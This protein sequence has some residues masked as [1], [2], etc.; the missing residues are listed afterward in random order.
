M[1]VS[2]W[3]KTFRSIYTRLPRRPPFGFVPSCG[4]GVTSSIRPI[5]SPARA[6]PRIAAWAPGP[7]DALLFPPGARTRTWIESIPFSFA[8]SA[9]FSAAF[10]AAYGEASSFA[11]FTTMPPDAFVIVSLPVMSVTVMM[12]LLYDA[13]MCAIPQRPISRTSFAAG[14]RLQ[15]PARVRHLLDAGTRGVQ[16]VREGAARVVHDRLLLLAGD[17]VTGRADRAA[18]HGEM[19]VDDELTALSRVERE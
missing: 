7:G 2:V 5:R 16:G 19:P 18:R 11:A 17:E 9:T 10:I 4:T 8:A 14:V 13:K 6:S 15:G 12:M 3:S 1:D